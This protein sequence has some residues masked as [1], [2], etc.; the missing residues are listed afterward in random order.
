[1]FR[2]ILKDTQGVHIS[3]H[4]AQQISL[5]PLRGSVETNVLDPSDASSS[6]SRS[7]VPRSVSSARPLRLV[8]QL[9]WVAEGTLRQ[10][11]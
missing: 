1:M 11:P 2:R 9:P 10:P 6:T 8:R 5:S 7:H 3:S 4:R